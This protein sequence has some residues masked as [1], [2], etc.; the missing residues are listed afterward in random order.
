MVPDREG[1]G[2]NPKFRRSPLKISVF[3]AA[4][5]YNNKHIAKTP[6]FIAYDAELTGYKQGSKSGHN[7]GWGADSRESQV[8]SWTATCS[9]Q[10]KPDT[11][12]SHH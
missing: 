11:L 7:R 9:L 2:S 1:V 5:A 3:C 8:M 10:V 12:S 6:V 4:V